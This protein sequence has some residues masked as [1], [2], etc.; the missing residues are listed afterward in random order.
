MGQQPPSQNQTNAYIPRNNIYKL[1]RASSLDINNAISAWSFISP[2][3]RLSPLNAPSRSRHLSMPSSLPRGIIRLQYPTLA[4]I[5]LTESITPLFPHPLYLPNFPNRFLELLHARPIVLDVIFLDL[6]HVVVG[7]GPVHALRVFPG[8]V[9]GEAERW[10]DD[11]H[12]V[13]DWGCKEAGY[14]AFIFGREME[15]WSD[16]AVRRNKGQPD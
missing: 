14:N 3:S 8:E 6:L 16:G 13:E 11:G 2:L 9:A 5:G 1:C 15:E 12:E 7:L 10:E 4:L